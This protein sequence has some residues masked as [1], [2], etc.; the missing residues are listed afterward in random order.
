MS[1]TWTLEPRASPE[2]ADAQEKACRRPSADHTPKQIQHSLYP[3][4]ADRSP[5]LH[6]ACK[7]LW[8]HSSL[9]AANGPNLAPSI[10]LNVYAS[11]RCDRIDAPTSLDGG[12]YHFRDRR[13]W[14]TSEEARL[15]PRRIAALRD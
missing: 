13:F 14:P 3:H 15:C 2:V 4:T 1:A 8:L 9:A 11:H 7:G 6:S 10:I 5:W 12:S